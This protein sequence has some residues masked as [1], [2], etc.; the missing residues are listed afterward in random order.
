VT[1]K[2][3]ATLK[4]LRE[5]QF[6]MSKLQHWCSCAE[7]GSTEEAEFYFSAFLAAARSVTNVLKAE[8]PEKYVAWS[9]NWRG[10]RSDRERFLLQRFV[11]ARNRALKRETPNVREDR[12]PNGQ[13]HLRALP[14][15]LIFFFGEDDQSLPGVRIL[16]CRL[17][18]GDPEEEV[19]P[20]CIEYGK[21]LTQL[22]QDF[23]HS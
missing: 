1:A 4:K 9:P 8:E 2:I 11:D 19:L 14:P 18:P 5:A 21:L 13:G 16:K 7:A 23:Q 12:S 3:P 22:V 6:F 10:A 20:L 15:E 17:R